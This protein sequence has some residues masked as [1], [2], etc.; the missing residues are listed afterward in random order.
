MN[1]LEDAKGCGWGHNDDFENWIGG[2]GWG[3]NDDGGG[4]F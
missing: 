2:C 1:I 3:H 4:R